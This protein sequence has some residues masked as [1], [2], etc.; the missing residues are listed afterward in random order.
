MPVLVIECC[1]MMRYKWL[2][3]RMCKMNRERLQTAGTLDE[4]FKL[5]GKM[6][7]GF[8][9]LCLAGVIFFIHSVFSRHK[10]NYYNKCRGL[11]LLREDKFYRLQWISSIFNS[12]FL[13]LCGLFFYML[14][15][16]PYNLYLPTIIFHI[17]NRFSLF[18]GKRLNYIE[19]E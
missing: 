2:S 12:V 3:Y 1:A 14:N 10:L 5:G 17:F 11:I 6:P 4:R 15:P 16:P 9:L 18:V 8:L 7:E 19:I 13:I